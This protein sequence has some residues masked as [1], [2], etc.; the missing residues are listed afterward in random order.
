MLRVQKHFIL[1]IKVFKEFS[2][3]NPR[4][5]AISSNFLPSMHI[6]HFS[7]VQSKQNFIWFSHSK[8][9]LPMIFLEEKKYR[10]LNNVREFENKIFKFT[11]ICCNVEQTN[12]K[13]ILKTFLWKGQEVCA[14]NIRGYGRDKEFCRYYFL[15]YNS[16]KRINCVIL[17]KHPKQFR[18]AGQC[19]V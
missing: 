8:F 1:K 6:G 18:N 3:N 13:Y 19:K 15:S 2:S 17:P 12:L 16:I 9:Y 5:F 4:K 7:P 10:Y 14:K 11:R